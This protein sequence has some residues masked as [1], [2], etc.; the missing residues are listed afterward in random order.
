MAPG[1]DMEP[2]PSE[3]VQEHRHSW[4]FLVFAAKVRIIPETAKC[5]TE[6]LLFFRSSRLL[7]LD[8]FRRGKYLAGRIKRLM[9][10]TQ[11]I[12]PA[13]NTSPED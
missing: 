9:Y 12:W 10:D 11:K 8:F 1:T 6:N 5:L 2:S 4:W 7:A 13:N 3:A